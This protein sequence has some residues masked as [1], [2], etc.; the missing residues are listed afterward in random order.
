MIDHHFN[1]F[2]LVKISCPQNNSK[3]VSFI[4]SLIQLIVTTCSVQCATIAIV[5]VSNRKW[6]KMSKQKIKIGI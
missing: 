5:G 6:A 4:S 1:V 3:C 2:L